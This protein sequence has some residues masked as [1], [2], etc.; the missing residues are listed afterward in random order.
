MCLRN[1]L[2][3]WNVHGI[4]NTSGLLQSEAQRYSCYFCKRPEVF[5]ISRTDQKSK[6]L[7]IFIFYY[8]NLKYRNYFYNLGKIKFSILYVIVLTNLLECK[9]EK[10]NSQCE[11]GQLKKQTRG[12]LCTCDS[13]V[14]LCQSQHLCHF[15]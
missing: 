13:G 14:A 3:F 5:M 9:T 7:L 6:L 2:D 10:R 8:K 11:H 15:G 4:L 1:E 12:L